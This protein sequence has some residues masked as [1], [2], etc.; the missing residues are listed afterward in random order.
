MELGS[1]RHRMDHDRLFVRVVVEHDDL[2]QLA[3]AIRADDEISSFAWYHL[4]GIA[5]SVVDVFLADAVLPRA[6]R[7]LHADKV[8]L[9]RRIVKPI[10]SSDVP[11]QR[12]VLNSVEVSVV[13]AGDEDAGRLAA[14]RP[15]WV[16]LRQPPA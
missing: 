8:A 2:Q 16:P 1:Q 10:L 9:S 13:H 12:V 6:V 3:G 4:Q 14:R 15:P 11:Y 7:D 5:Q